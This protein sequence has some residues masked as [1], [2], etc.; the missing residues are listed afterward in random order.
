MELLGL[1]LALVMLIIFGYAHFKK[2]TIKIPGNLTSSQ[3][4]E[5]R[6]Q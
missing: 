1:V 2:N 3:D 5:W 4:D 6:R